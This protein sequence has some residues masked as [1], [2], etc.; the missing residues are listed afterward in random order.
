MTATVKLPPTLELSLRQ[1]CAASGESLSEVIRVALEA[2]LAAVNRVADTSPWSLGADLF[3]RYA[4]SGDLS[5]T[6]REQRGDVWDEM[7]AA[8]RA[9]LSP[10]KRSTRSRSDSTRK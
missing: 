8:K 7:F 10:R 3:G 6:Y 4:G 1:Y 9:A 2:H 5:Q